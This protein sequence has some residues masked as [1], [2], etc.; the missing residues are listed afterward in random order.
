MAKPKRA[1][2]KKSRQ[3]PSTPAKSLGE[4]IRV[5]DMLEALQQA[6]AGKTIQA[7]RDA[8]P[9]L[10]QVF[11]ELNALAR[12]NAAPENP[13]LPIVSLPPEPRPIGSLTDAHERI[14]DFTARLRDA[15]MALDDA[16]ARIADLPSA[17]AAHV[18]AQDMI[19]HVDQAL[20]RCHQGEES[21]HAANAQIFRTREVT[22][23][24]TSV[25][26][27]M[28]FRLEFMKNHADAVQAVLRELK[29]LMENAEILAA[30]AGRHGAS[31]HVIVDKA[32]DLHGGIDAHIDDILELTS[33][34][35]NDSV[36]AN[37]V[38]EV[39][40]INREAEITNEI[41]R[42]FAAI[43]ESCT[44][45]R[46]L[47]QGP[48]ESMTRW[49][50]ATDCLQ[51][52][53]TVLSTIVPD[54]EALSTWSARLPTKNEQERIQCMDKTNEQWSAVLKLTK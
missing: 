40:C 31:F 44:H 53:A 41:E 12:R 29:M 32:A 37:S 7:P 3:A 47:A 50:Q 30:R 42:S 36:G 46:A 16:C 13:P 49:K 21:T 17:N 35:R 9:E 11:L 22:L 45:A 52:A 27:N 38:V 25:I 34:L 20:E 54:A 1:A 23:H 4:S 24:A 43:R 14:A 6:N 26:S 51:Q 15:S 19:R 5:S 33:T 28:G 48:A 18:N 8:T 10:A 2:S 39:N